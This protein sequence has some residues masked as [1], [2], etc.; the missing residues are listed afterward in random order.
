MIYFPVLRQ[1]SQRPQQA[2]YADGVEMLF[3]RLKLL[4]RFLIKM[5]KTEK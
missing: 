4:S 2:R 5:L 1:P 3:S